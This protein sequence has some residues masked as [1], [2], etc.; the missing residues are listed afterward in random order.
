MRAFPGR[1][2]SIPTGNMD[3]ARSRPL[4]QPIWRSPEREADGQARRPPH[5]RVAAGGITGR[6]TGYRWSDD[7]HRHLSTRAQ[8]RSAPAAVPAA[9]PPVAGTG[10]AGPGPR[11]DARPP[12]DRV[13]HRRCAPLPGWPSFAFTDVAAIAF[14]A[15]PAHRWRCSAPPA[16]A[17]ARPP[18]VAA[19]IARRYG[20][21]VPIGVVLHWLLWREPLSFGVLEA[22]GVTVVL[23]AAA[24]AR[25]DCRQ[26]ADRRPGGRR[27]VG[28]AGGRQPRLAGGGGAGRHLPAGDL[29]G[30]RPGRRGGRPHGAARGPALGRR[31]RGV[32]T[33]A[34]LVMA[35]EGTVPDR[36]P[37]EVPF[38]VPG[39][40]GTVIVYF[41]VQFRWPA[42]LAGV[43]SVVRRR[44]PGPR[45]LRGPLPAVRPPAPRRR[46][47]RP[48]RGDGHPL[49]L[50]ITATL[51]VLAPHV[52]RLPWSPAPARAGPLTP[53]A[54][55]TGTRS[56]GRPAA[57]RRAE[58]RKRPADLEP[59]AHSARRTAPS[60]HSAWW[61]GEKHGDPNGHRDTATMSHGR[62]QSS[63]TPMACAS[64]D[65]RRRPA[66]IPTGHRRAGPPPHRE[67]LPPHGAPRR[68]PTKPSTQHREVMAPSPRGRDKRGRSDGGEQG[69]NAA[70]TAGRAPSLSTLSMLE[71]MASPARVTST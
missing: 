33:G 30:L 5:E 39:L 7:E 1:Q 55:G 20:P 15:P 48:G 26:S 24:A 3:D 44:A 49:A 43:D 38:V 18:G 17:G 11:G 50:A 22:L 32:A 58:H 19:E 56:R 8:R 53:W 23:A 61:D 28:E 67:R 70:S 10:P 64:A 41:L 63:T 34:V 52:P 60:G 65:Q 13:A 27:V 36:Y 9:W 68:S 66:T 35:V 29:P 42:A 54:G 71:G 45:H 47:A 6:R 25:A 21:L 31:R 59:L 37:G 12:P 69:Q 40:A 57:F 2:P 46:D 4:R 51:C 62:L 16:A 14:S